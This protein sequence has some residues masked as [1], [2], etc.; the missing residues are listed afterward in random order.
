MDD[1]PVIE[2]GR[3]HNDVGEPLVRV[4]GALTGTVDTWKR[5]I[6]GL[7]GQQPAPAI[8]PDD[9]EFKKAVIAVVFEMKRKRVI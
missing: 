4:G 3:E 7:E 9:P 2:I 5:A 1:Y 8:S 6:A